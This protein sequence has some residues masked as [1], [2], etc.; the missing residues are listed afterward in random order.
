M[1]IDLRSDT[2][3]LP[4]PDMKAAM[5]EAPLGDDVFGEDPT[6]NALQEQ[7]ASRF[8]MEA[9]LF[10]PSGT[11]CNQIGIRI[12]TQPQ[13]QVIC[14]KRSHVYLYEGGGL[15]YNSMVS[16]RLVDG[17]RGIVSPEMVETEINPENIHFPSSRLLVIENTC[18]KGG[19]SYYTLDQIRDLSAMCKRNGLKLHV[20]GARLFNA[21]IATGEDAQEYGKYVDTISL[22]LSK[23]LGAPVGSILLGS[24]QDI[25]KA[26][27]VRKVL[28]GGMRQAGVL[29][30][31]GIY[32][33]THHVDR[34]AEDHLRARRIESALKGASPRARGSPR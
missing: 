2:F 31:A 4:T 18:N 13:D 20:D 26:L 16:A 33:L 7:A 8:G 34:L 14:D 24:K 1:I 21:L 27:R 5:M 17:P 10:C 30:A 22:C 19:G 9:G 28:G 23:G 11:M 29:A 6:I 3:T 32:A 25:A 12:H 15:A